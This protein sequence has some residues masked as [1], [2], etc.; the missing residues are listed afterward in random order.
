MQ[1]LETHAKALLTENVTLMGKASSVAC[2]VF[3]IFFRLRLGNDVDISVAL[4]NIV[5]D[6]YRNSYSDVTRCTMQ[7][8]T[9]STINVKQAHC[10]N[11][12]N[13]CKGS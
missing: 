5:G 3:C 9:A 7:N 8:T 12:H 13:F 10:A 6:I 1:T 2:F 11:V 4:R